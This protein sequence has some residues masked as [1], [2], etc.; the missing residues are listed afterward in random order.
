MKK[1][2]IFCCVTF[3]RHDKSSGF[4]EHELYYDPAISINDYCNFFIEQT[5]NKQ[6]IERVSIFSLELSEHDEDGNYL[7]DGSYQIK[8]KTITCDFTYPPTP[9]RTR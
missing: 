3:V 7:F 9:L 2:R 8:R 6:A 1:P 5:R 4:E